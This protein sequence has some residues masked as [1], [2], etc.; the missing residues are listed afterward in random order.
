VISLILALFF[1]QLLAALYGVSRRTIQFILDPDKLKENLKRRKE[2]GGSMQY[3]EKDR[4]SSYVKG[5][6]R[7]K[8]KLKVDGKIKQE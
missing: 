8:Q 7:Y 5:H 2:R 4:H 3:Y 6:R 1:R